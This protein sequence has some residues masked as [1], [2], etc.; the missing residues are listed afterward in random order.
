M[1]EQEQSKQE[2]DLQ[3]TLQE[4]GIAII[5]EDAH[6]QQ[7]NNLVR[8]RIVAKKRDANENIEVLGDT[9]EAALRS[10]VVLSNAT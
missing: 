9:R 7:G 3:Q 2:L 1:N 4:R 8:Y 6:Y 10:L 5:T